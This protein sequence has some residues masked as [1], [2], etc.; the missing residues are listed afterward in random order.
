MWSRRCQQEQVERCPKVVSQERQRKWM[1]WEEA[2]KRKFSWKELLGMKADQITFTMW[3]TYDVLQSPQNLSLRY[4]EDPTCPLCSSPANLNHILVSCKTRLK[5]GCDTWGKNQILRYLAAMLESRSM[6]I[7]ALPSHPLQWQKK[8]SVK[9]R[10][11]P[12]H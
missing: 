11:N 12:R 5:Q 2:E 3:A 7:N 8:L 9:V 10:S 6:P 1:R 4:G